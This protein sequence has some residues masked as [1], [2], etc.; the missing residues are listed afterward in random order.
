MLNSWEQ[1]RKQKQPPT[2]LIPVVI[3]HGKATWAYE[4][5]PSYFGAVDAELSRFLPDFAYLLVNISRYSDEQ[6]L[7]FQNRFLA[8]SLFLMKHRTNEARLLAQRDR[9]F[10]WLEN[11][12]D[13]E[14]GSDYLQTAVIYLFRNL[15]VR[16]RTFYDQ[17]FVSS[18]NNQKAM[19]TYDYLISEG[20]REGRVE[21][22]V[23]TVTK[24]FRTAH[25]QGMDITKL[26]NQ[27]YGLPPEQLRAIVD[28]IRRGQ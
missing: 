21:G 11:T 23:E 19:S 25:E 10:V 14:R 20:R 12:S 8:T 22:R 24:L 27:D 26:L 9:L 15:D 18:Q 7:S 6:I 16:S 1:A 5:L 13:P 28:A 2:L 17:L 3:Y 4:P